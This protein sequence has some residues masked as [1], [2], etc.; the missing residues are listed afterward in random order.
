[1][2]GPP[3]IP[4]GPLLWVLWDFAL[5]PVLWTRCCA[6]ELRQTRCS[7]RE[8]ERLRC[9]G[10]GCCPYD[11][12]FATN[13][14][15]SIFSLAIPECLLYRYSALSGEH[16]RMERWPSWSKEHDWKSCVRE[17]RTGS[18]NL[19]LSARFQGV[20]GNSNSFFFC[21]TVTI[22]DTF[23]DSFKNCYPP[24]PNSFLYMLFLA[25]SQTAL[26]CASGSIPNAT[27]ALKTDAS[28]STSSQRQAPS[29]PDCH[30]ESLPHKKGRPSRTAT[31]REVVMKQCA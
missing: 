1:M 30:R 25:T 6:A 7:V 19:P 18:S 10:A 29:H 31:G 11:N 28:H 12:F 3:G 13:C 16:H 5:W 9:I 4:G 14:P 20:T 26:L 27:P 24:C 8:Q 23:R 22:R 15:D 21:R 2:Q 17:Q